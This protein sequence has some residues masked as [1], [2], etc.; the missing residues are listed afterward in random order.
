[1]KPE[2]KARRKIDNLFKDAGWEVVDRMNYN[3]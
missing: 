2:E 3:P 1:M